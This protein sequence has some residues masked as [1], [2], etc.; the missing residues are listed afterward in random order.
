MTYL[1]AFWRPICHFRFRHLKKSLAK[2]LRYV[3]CMALM[4]QGRPAEHSE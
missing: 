4:G 2:W 3:G 1:L